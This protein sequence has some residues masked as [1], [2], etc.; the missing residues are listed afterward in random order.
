VVKIVVSV[1]AGALCLTLPIILP[2][3]YGLV[4]TVADRECDGG[5]V[6]E[7]AIHLPRPGGCCDPAVPEGGDV[8][9]EILLQT[10]INFPRFLPIFPGFL[11]RLSHLAPIY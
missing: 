7:E 5:I 10:H 4:L 6:Y 9:M 3:R 1:P 11:E 2:R 8:A